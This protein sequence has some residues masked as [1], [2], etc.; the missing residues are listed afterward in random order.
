MIF[1]VE[2][3]I[4]FW[5]EKHLYLIFF[6]AITLISLA[7]R[8][9][10]K[11]ADSGDLNAFL[12]PW[13]DYI[14]ENGGLG[15]LDMQVGDYNIPYQTV[16][17]LLTYL[18]LE[19]TYLYKLFSCIFDYFLAILAGC[20]VYSGSRDKRK[21]KALLAY[22]CV[23]L[24]PLVFLNSSYWAQCDSVF[25]SFSVLSLLFFSREKYGL[26]FIAFGLAFAFKLQAIFLLPLYL[27][28]YVYKK[29]FSFLYFFL[30]PM[31]MIFMATAGLVK[32]RGIKDVF[33]IYANQTTTYTSLYI[34]YPSFWG[35]FL[36][37]TPAQLSL[38]LKPLAI[39]CTIAVLVLLLFWLYRHQA[40]LTPVTLVYMA[41]L[42]IFT[43]VLFLP[44]MHERY[45]FQYEILSILLAFFLPK[46]AWLSLGLHI[47]SF[48]TYSIYLFDF[49]R[50]RFYQLSIINVMI[51]VIYLYLFYRYVQ[52]KELYQCDSLHSAN[53]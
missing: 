22:S 26:S 17:A 41:F 38:A 37:D 19:P 50:E 1:S 8:F 30:I 51:Y 40:M 27:F 34:N 24:S 2:Q 9:L 13:F 4:L 10:L 20:F 28:L 43:C 18:P 49:T 35:L 16:I 14:K 46:T 33:F 45:G 11:D 39:V 6:F 21:L 52:D 5:V 44:N 3:K 36:S 12:L 32:G 31:T 29:R 53:L 7:I 15:S 25:T 42:V 47:L 23:L 48:R